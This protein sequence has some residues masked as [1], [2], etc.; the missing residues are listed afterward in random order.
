MITWYTLYHNGK[1]KE[2][3]LGHPACP[4]PKAAVTLSEQQPYADKLQCSG[5]DSAEA[6]VAAMAEEGE[7]REGKD[8]TEEKREEH[9]H[10]SDY[11]GSSRN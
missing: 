8:G 11:V 9:H 4:T 7:S 6:G 2:Y 10:F 5:S 1:Y 3:L